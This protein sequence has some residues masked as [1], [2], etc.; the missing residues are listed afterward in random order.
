MMDGVV[1]LHG[2]LRT[3]RSMADLERFLQR[4]GYATLNIGYSSKYS[5]EQLTELLHEKIAAF[6][7]MVPGE[8]HFVG[9]SMGGLLIRAYIKRFPPEKL[10]RVVMLATPNHGSE[11][12]DVMKDWW[13]YKVVY[14]ESGQQLSTSEDG[15]EQTLGK[16]T[17][18]LGIIAGDRPLSTISTKF[19]GQP[20][21]GKV[22]VA[23]TKM[24]GMTDHIVLHT[25][26]TLML[27]NKAVREQTLYFLQHGR[28]LHG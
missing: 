5:L 8:L 4:A 10:G 25:S 11:L 15:F 23:S 16:V 19:F 3:R 7:S 24:T 18:E 22:S 1:L 20:N 21:D 26:H 2:I 12:V 6:A 9:H 28:F 27:V 13:L 17:Y 14:G